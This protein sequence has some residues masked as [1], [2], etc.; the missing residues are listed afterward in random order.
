M[1]F[2][3]EISYHMSGVFLYHYFFIFCLDGEP[4]NEATSNGEEEATTS[5]MPKASVE[6]NYNSWWSLFDVV[7]EG[8]ENI[9][10]SLGLT[11]L[12]H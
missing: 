9:N 7:K 1:N 11:W 10:L 4:A 12:L 6:K 2:I 8:I 5:A 3:S